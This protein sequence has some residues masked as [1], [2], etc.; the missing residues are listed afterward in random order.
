MR[1]VYIDD[2]GDD[3]KD[4]VCFAALI[5]DAAQWY[6]CTERLEDM[7]QRMKTRFGI[8]VNVE[9]HATDF[10]AGRKPIARH[11]IDIPTRVKIAGGI[12]TIISR[13]PSLQIIGVVMKHN[14][15][16]TAFD[17]LLNRID[18]N[19]RKV[20]DQAFIISD[21]GKDYNKLLDRKRRDNQIPSAFGDWGAGNLNTSIPIANIVERIWLRSSA[22]C[23]FIQA[24]DFCAYSL[25]RQ[26]APYQRHQDGGID[27]LYALLN[28]CLVRDA[29]RR[30]PQGIVRWYKAP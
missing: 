10:L 21:E 26:E 16:D 4:I 6:A 17:W 3:T 1:I 11:P 13:L 15:K 19:V 8:G 22:S 7:R 30:D 29:N 9:L 18:T 28:P 23:R 20:G 12:L 2:S 14:D 27:K 25:L 5:I 24:A